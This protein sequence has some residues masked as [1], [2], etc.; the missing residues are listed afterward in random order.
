MCD[1][2]GMNWGGFLGSKQ[3][4]HI[5]VHSKD[6]QTKVVYMFVNCVCVYALCIYVCVCVCVYVYICVYLCVCVRIVYVC[7]YM[8][9]C[10]CMRLT[11][12][13]FSSDAFKFS[14]YWSEAFLHFGTIGSGC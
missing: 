11:K 7:P 3:L 12:D 6:L 14:L 1:I 13:I 9:V 4:Y 10:V 5:T 2:N 8:Y